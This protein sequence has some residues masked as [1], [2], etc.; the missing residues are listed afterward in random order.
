[1]KTGEYADSKILKLRNAHNSIVWTFDLEVDAVLIRKERVSFAYRELFNGKARMLL[2][3]HFTQMPDEIA[4]LRYLS[5]HRPH[6]ILAGNDLTENIGV[7]CIA[8][9]GRGLH[10]SMAIMKDAVEQTAVE[11]VFYE[12]GTVDCKCC[13]GCWFEYKSF[14]INDEAYNL[15]FLIGSE[16]MFLFGVFNCSMRHFE[17]WKP[18]ILKALEHTEIF[19]GI[20]QNG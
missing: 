17:E 9:N 18:F 5:K 15:Q 19:D 6:I 4:E 1:M 14:T 12:K 7:S 8:R 10:E 16:Q 11:T 3:C 13:D 20:A 2:P